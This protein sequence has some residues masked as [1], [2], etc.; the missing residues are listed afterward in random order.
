ML[1]VAAGLF[2]LGVLVGFV[3]SSITGDLIRVLLFAT[4]LVGYRGGGSTAARQGQPLT[5][6]RALP[7]RSDLDLQ[8][9]R[10]GRSDCCYKRQGPGGL[11]PVGIAV[12]AA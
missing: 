3:V 11:S 9:R 5:A 7:C 6:A 10:V 2:L 1:L 12:R 8:L 4:A